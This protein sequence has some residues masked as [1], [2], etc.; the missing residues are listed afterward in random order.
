MKNLKLITAFLLCASLTASAFMLGS[1]GDENE[2]EDE[3]TAE[4]TTAEE[5]TAAET[6]APK[7]SGFEITTLPTKLEYSVGEELDLTGMVCTLLYDNGTS[8]VTDEYKISQTGLLQTSDTTITV[9]YSTRW[10]ATF[11][12]TVNLDVNLPGSGTAEDPYMIS[13]ASEYSTFQTLLASG[14]TCEGKYFALA[15]DITITDYELWTPFSDSR[16]SVFAGIFDGRGHVLSAKMELRSETFAIPFFYYVK[17]TIMNTGFNIDSKGCNSTSYAVTRELD[18]GSDNIGGIMVN[19]FAVGSMY[20]SNS[21]TTILAGTT[22]NAKVSN[23]YVDVSLTGTTP[24][25]STGVT[26][27]GNNNTVTNAYYV[28]N[29]CTVQY[30]ENKVE[31]KTIVAEALNATLADAA[32]V[33]G[34]DVSALCSWT[35]DANGVPVLVAK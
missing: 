2:P 9:R 3:T 19:C 30:N 26:T 14:E 34:V 23:V 21:S 27:K 22:N 31:D 15:N 35:T 18:S 1:C 29:G 33:A 6:E 10:K 7:I 20:C 25:S 17:G 8:V 16:Q 24:G 32:A 4:E 11:D 5:T 28:P 12:I 13:T